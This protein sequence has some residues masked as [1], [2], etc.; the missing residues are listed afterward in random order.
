LQQSIPEISI[1]VPIKN[2]EESIP[3]LAREISA[4]MAPYNWSWEC[5]WIDD[6]STDK[7]LAVLKELVGRDHHHRYLSF[8]QNAGQSAALWA[9]FKA[10]RGAILASLD[11]DGQNDPAD[12]PRLIQILQSG[13]VD[14]VNGVRQQ[15]ADSFF[16]KAASRV[17][18]GFRNF[19]TGKTVS[20]V[21]CSTRCFKRECTRQLPPFAGMHRF[22]PTLVAL[23]GFRLSEVPVNHRPRTRGKTKYSINN[24]L[25]VGLYDLF[26]IRWFKK[27]AFHY[28]IKE[29]SS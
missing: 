8:A 11:G 20:D 28:S 16:R 14:M 23:Y 9:G 6:G 12:L 2:E 5:I 4:S 1:I 22:L 17:G 13:Q 21:G 24:R 27:R 19:F 10:S 29:T 15:R 7:S 3:V 25:W 18:N 26:G